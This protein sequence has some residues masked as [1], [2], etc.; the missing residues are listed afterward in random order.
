ML[1][2]KLKHDG[3]LS[4]AELVV[5]VLAV[6][7]LVIGFGFFF[8]GALIY[9]AW[10]LGVVPT[11]GAPP[12]AYWPACWLSLGLSVVTSYFRRSSN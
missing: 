4:G 3:G 7:L 12:I 8:G 10:N 5:V 2:V 11:F 9:G 6:V 1:N